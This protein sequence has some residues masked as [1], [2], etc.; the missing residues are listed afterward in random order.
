MKRK[1]STF[2][3]SVPRDVVGK[4]QLI[5]MV[6]VE[7]RRMGLICNGVLPCTTCI[8]R[9]QGYKCVK[10]VAG[11]K[12]RTDD[13]ASEDT[14]ADAHLKMSEI[15]ASMSYTELG[16]TT[17]D[18]AL[19][20][21]IS[22]LVEN[23]L[24]TKSG[25]EI[26]LSFRGKQAMAI[27]DWFQEFIKE[28]FPQSRLWGAMFED[29]YALRRLLIKL[30]KAS[31]VLPSHLFLDEIRCFNRDPVAGG[32][33]AD[34]CR[35]TYYAQPVALK[36]L[37]VFKTNE[38]L[39][40]ARKAFCD[41]ALVWQHLRHKH[42]LPFLGIDLR[43]F[44]PLHCMVSP[45][46]EN[47]NIMQCIN[48]LHEK[49]VNVPFNRWVR[50]ITEGLEYLHGQRIVH[51]DL[52]GANI[53]ITSD[54]HV[55]LCDFGLAKFADSTTASWGSIAGGAVRWLAPEVLKGSRPTFK[56]D[57]YAFGCVC[58]EIY[59]RK[60]PF[61]DIASDTQVVAR[62]LQGA[63][64]EKPENS[65]RFQ[66]GFWNLV[67]MCWNEDPADRPDAAFL[68]KWLD[69]KDDGLL[70][71]DYD[72]IFAPHPKRDRDK[73]PSLNYFVSSQDE[74]EAAFLDAHSAFEPSSFKASSVIKSAFG[75]P[76][77]E[78]NFSPSS[79]SFGVVSLPNSSINPSPEEAG[80][81]KM[82]PSRKLFTNSPLAQSFSTSSS[83]FTIISSGGSMP[84]AIN[85]SGKSVRFDTDNF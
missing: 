40:K 11:Q 83:P 58:L 47:G 48:T 53:L 50:Q 13:S 39:E 84:V 49:Q 52:R 27:L 56:S 10:R 23:A 43:T 3:Y 77:S 34:I 24:K 38:D 37:R 2:A 26:L 64:P 61:A 69:P 54:L 36:R 73:S 1:E 70:M 57:T 25:K 8:S 74:E 81:I 18:H 28:P 20:Q 71:A 59:T 12:R 79:S 30:S 78:L 75:S 63:R 55:Q 82:K 19:F 9:G 33:F 44:A 21:H 41:E 76:F 68:M 31:G 5:A 46:M 22:R 80:P 4:R 16:F 14:I 32:G 85:A 29:D 6:C 42:I 60:H 17:R 15:M 51:G 35:G 45:W 62:V 65:G 66:Q 7:C 72:L 67:K